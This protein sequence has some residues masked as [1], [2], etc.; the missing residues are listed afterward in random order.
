MANIQQVKIA[1]GFKG[2]D[3]AE[4][5]SNLTDKDVLFG[6]RK[7]FY[8]DGTLV[9]YTIADEDSGIGVFAANDNRLGTVTDIANA[10]LFFASDEAAYITG[11]TLVIDGGQVLPE[12]LMALEEMVAP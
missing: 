9:G 8:I 12:S 6:P 1:E 7:D 5:R 11:Q 4:F 10:V 3:P 2:L